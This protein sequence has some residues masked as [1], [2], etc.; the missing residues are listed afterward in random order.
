M[1]KITSHGCATLTI[2]RGTTP[3]QVLLGDGKTGKSYDIGEL[4]RGI[5]RECEPKQVV[6]NPPYNNIYREITTDRS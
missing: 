3:D 2:E 1:T 6:L 4:I 5:L